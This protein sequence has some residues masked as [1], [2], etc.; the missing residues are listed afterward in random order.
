MKKI[1]LT[2]AEKIEI[3]KKATEF[4]SSLQQHHSQ[5]DTQT[6]IDVVTGIINNIDVTGKSVVIVANFDIFM[7]VQ[8]LN[9]KFGL[10]ITELK[11]VT[12][13]KLNFHSDS[14]IYVESLK[15]IE[16][17]KKFDVGI[18]NPP[19]SKDDELLYP[20]F[21]AKML[22]CCDVVSIIM[23]NNLESNQ[24]RL[25]KHNTLVKR[26]L[27]TETDVTEY[28]N[29]GIKSIHN[30]IASKSQLNT[31]IKT[32]KLS[33]YVPILPDR[34]RL[35]A[36]RGLNP[37]FNKTIQS[38]NIDVEMISSVYR[39]DVLQHKTFAVSDSALRRVKAFQI[40]SPWI[41]L[42]NE[43]PSNGLFNAVALPYD[44]QKWFSGVFAL[45]AESEQD[46]LELKAW[47]QSDTIRNEVNTLLQMNN[48][49]SFSGVMFSMLP[50][51]K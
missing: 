38:D 21:F 8:Y 17:N 3:T 22:E 12:D 9:Q 26:H 18:L 14:I 39:G 48:S 5:Q 41:V 51:H 27:I 30:V 43:N 10:G 35:N 31:V 40:T 15:E 29:V 25:K 45:E 28:F 11:L 7:Y 44:N 50:A 16:L 13:V 46:A 23:P 20:V 24:I 49:Y 42:V 6:S 32:N 47:L 2:P 37:F 34:A 33:S 4:F 19:Y 1:V 36:R